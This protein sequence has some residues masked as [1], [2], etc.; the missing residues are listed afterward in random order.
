MAT[1]DIVRGLADRKWHKYVHKW[2]VVGKGFL[3][4][5]TA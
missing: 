2:E 3:V 4:K 5:V 1:E